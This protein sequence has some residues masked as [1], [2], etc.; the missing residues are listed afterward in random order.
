MWVHAGKHVQSL[1]S[2]VCLIQH[3]PHDINWNKQHLYKLIEDIS[4]FQLNVVLFVSSDI[5]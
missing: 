2:N 1:H 4:I 3:F 5:P